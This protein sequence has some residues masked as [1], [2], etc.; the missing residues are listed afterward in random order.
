V[1]GTVAATVL[2]GSLC[3]LFNAASAALA[4]L[5]SPSPERGGEAPPTAE[6]RASPVRAPEPDPTCPAGPPR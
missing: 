5:T 4:T 6:G 2:G 1:I 3:L